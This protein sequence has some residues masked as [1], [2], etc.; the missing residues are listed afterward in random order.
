[1]TEE[2][3][4]NEKIIETETQKMLRKSEKRKHDGAA[5]FVSKLWRIFHE[6]IINETLWQL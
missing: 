6:N 5:G 2:Q 3:E 1:M 4:K